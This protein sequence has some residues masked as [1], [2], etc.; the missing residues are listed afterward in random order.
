MYNDDEVTLIKLRKGC[1]NIYQIKGN[2]LFKKWGNPPP[3]SLLQFGCSD[4]QE[5]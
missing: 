4:F 1:C 3:P 2:L 5:G